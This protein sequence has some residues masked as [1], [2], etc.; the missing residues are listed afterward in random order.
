VV[1]LA[2]TTWPSL[3][4]FTPISV[5]LAF[6]GSSLTSCGSLTRDPSAEHPSGIDVPAAEEASAGALERSRIARSSVVLA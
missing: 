1:Y 4:S 6:E 2:Q 5:S 3:S